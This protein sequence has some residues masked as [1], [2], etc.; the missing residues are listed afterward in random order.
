MNT[1]K[2]LFLGG[3][4]FLSTSVVK[5][6][7][8]NPSFEDWQTRNFGVTQFQ[9]PSNWITNN[10]IFAF[11]QP[12]NL[13]IK[14]TTDA[15]TGAL[16]IELENVPDTSEQKQGASL[17]SGTMNIFTQEFNTKF[18][19]NSKPTGL[20]FFYKYYPFSTDSFSVYIT[21]YKNGEYAGGG[22]FQGGGK[23]ED[24]TKVSIP[25][26]YVDMNQAPDS[27]SIV[28]YASTF[29]QIS[30][31]TRLI[32]DDF[33]LID[34]ALSVNSISTNNDVKIYPNPV[35]NELS[36]DLK[37]YS[38][39]NAK[40]ISLNGNTVF[41][42]TLNTYQNKLDISGLDSGIYVVQ[43][44]TNLGVTNYKIQVNR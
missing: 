15:H 13:P 6:Q 3:I 11:T 7:L 38:Q 20:D 26:E 37:N 1:I 4:L 24:Y 8:Q 14:K 21:T 33:T 29:E 12:V 10:I 30:E 34:E 9:D 31:G 2:Q 36:I 40:I 22:F 44:I 17:V 43:V 28:V 5:A 32:L 19:L 35:Q 42:T 18:K 23:V 27:A 41:E 39:A 16:A 25:I